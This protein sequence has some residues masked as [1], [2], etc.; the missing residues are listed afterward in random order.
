MRETF[1]E[2]MD[3]IERNEKYSVW[4]KEQTV[5]QRLQFLKNELEEMQAGLKKND[6]LNIKEEM[7]D[8][9]Y[10]TFVLAKAI[11][12]KH[13]ADLKEIMRIAIDKIKRRKPYLFE[14]RSVTI[15]EARK[16]WQEIKQQ[17]KEGKFK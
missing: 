13:S 16:I 17:E 12:K 15:E 5:E 4:L 7:A 6:L 9:L 10:V 8:I 2:F 1:L 11:E 14:G 3:L